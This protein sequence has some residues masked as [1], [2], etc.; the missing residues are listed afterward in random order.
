MT[1]QHLCLAELKCVYTQ[2][3]ERERLPDIMKGSYMEDSD[4][5]GWPSGTERANAEGLVLEIAFFCFHT[6][7]SVIRCPGSRQ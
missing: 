5:E 7:Q 6:L 3:F 4:T 1:V 2:T